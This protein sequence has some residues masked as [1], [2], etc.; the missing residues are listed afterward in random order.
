MIEQVRL[1][2]QDQS[3]VLL[4]APTG[5]GKTVAALYPALERALRDGLRIFFVT[6]KTTQQLLAVA[7]LHQIAAQGVHFTAVH[8]RAKEK[9]CLNEVYYCHENVCDFAKDYVA[10]LERSGL[11]EDLL[12]TPRFSPPP[13]NATASARSSSH[14]TWR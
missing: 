2:L 8:L 11:V 6:A 5:I 1:A 12:R 10:K 14:W 7:T 9:S 4:A 13:R 3:C